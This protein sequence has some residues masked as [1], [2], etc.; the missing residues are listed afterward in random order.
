MTLVHYTGAE[1]L[2][3]QDQLAAAY[4][5]VF[6]RPPFGRRQDSID[7]FLQRLTEDVHRPGFL[8][9]IATDAA[10]GITGFATG[11]VTQAPFRT[12]RSYGK[13]LQQL[14]QHRVE[15]LLIGKLEVDEL[16][17][18]PTARGQGLARRLLAELTA[19]A[20]EQSAWLLTPTWA[21]QTVAFYH[22]IGWKPA[23]NGD[24]VTV[25]LAPSHTVLDKV[26]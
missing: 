2:K 26:Q 15:N 16:G 3:V 17:V 14:G 20:P 23:T 21:S 12:D 10:A 18:R 24:D 19:T 9:V 8:A 7:H 11:W 4:G 13:V 1:L 25:F 5:D 22:H 6:S